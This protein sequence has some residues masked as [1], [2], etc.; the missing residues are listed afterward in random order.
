MARLND[1][2]VATLMRSYVECVVSDVKCGTLSI[3][4]E[5]DAAYRA[6]RRSVVLFR[7]NTRAATYATYVRAS[8]GHP[9]WPSSICAESGERL[10]PRY[11]SSALGSEKGDHMSRSA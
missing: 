4:Y 7:I 1:E 8:S 5:T 6:A 3:G 11:V 2:R 10:A 9:R